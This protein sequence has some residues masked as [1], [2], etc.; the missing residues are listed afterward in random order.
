M[1]TR[2]SFIVKLCISL[3]GLCTGLTGGLLSLW[4][5]TKRLIVPK[6][7]TR[8]SLIYRNPA[9][10][11]PRNLDVTPLPDFGTMGATDI[12]LDPTSWRLEVV[13]G[14]VSLLHVTF[15]EILTM[16]AIEKRVL[17]ICPGFFVNYGNWKGISIMALL[18][19]AGIDADVT[20]VEVKGHDRGSEKA[21]T[22]PLEHIRSNQVFLAYEVNGTRLPKKHGFPLRVVAEDYFGYDWVKYVFRVTAAIARAQK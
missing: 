4:A 14:S 17:M 5:H 20:S 3:G 15:D 21:V 1:Q 11:D 22:Y 13:G 18:E 19:R 16:P 12:A 10:L 2:R 6:G 7:T 9:D 8:E